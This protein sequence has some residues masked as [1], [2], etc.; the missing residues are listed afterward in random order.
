MAQS[1]TP[2][3]LT[4]L[5]KRLRD[6]TRG[7]Q[8]V[9]IGDLLDAVGQRSFGPVVL[10]AGLLTLA[11]LIGDIPGVPTLLGLLVLLTLGQL[12][13]QRPAIWIPSQLS[14]R[15]LARDKLENGLDW[16]DRP[17][18]FIDRWTSQR[19]TW[20]VRG[21]GR[22]LTALICMLVAAALPAMELVPFSANGGGLA[23]TLFG[24]ALVADDGLFALLGILFTGG[25]LWIV[26]SGLMGL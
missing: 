7:Q 22:Y 14:N 24:I 25:T 20:L 3:S 5:L 13:F 6:N 15:Q 19:L 12:L 21:P 4:D 16:M 11:P 26:I 2:A 9:S 1:Q 10:I 8:Q 23:L 17:A 18:R